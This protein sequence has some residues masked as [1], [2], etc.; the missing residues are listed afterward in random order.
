MGR[1][2]G[3]P[4]SHLKKDAV[5][6]T[7]L[8]PLFDGLA[9]C[10]LGCVLIGSAAAKDG[11]NDLVDQTKRQQEVAAQKAESDI[12]AS[13]VA[14]EKLASVDPAKAIDLLKNAQAKLEDTTELSE[15]RR[16]VLK[17]VFADRIRVAEAMIEQAKQDAKD[18]TQRADDADRKV[19]EEKIKRDLATI[20]VLRDSGKTDEA[21]RQA[22]ELARRFPNN[23]A[24]QASKRI[25]DTNE[26][27]AEARRLQ[28][29]KEARTDKVIGSDIT[30]SATPP[31]DDIEFPPPEQWARLT[32]A[33][34]KKQL[35]EKEQQILKTLDSPIKADFKDSRLEDVIDFLQTRTGLSII[36]D[37]AALDEANASYDTLVSANFKQ[38]VSVRTLLRVVLGKAGL[39]YIVKDEAITVMTPERAKATL[40][41]K[42]YYLGDLVGYTDVTL[43]PV[44]TQAK[45][46]AAGREIVEM[47]KGSVDPNSWRD[48]GGEGTIVFD[49]R[50]LSIIVKQTAEVHSILGSGYK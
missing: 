30:K 43:G 35:T 24:A 39:T 41:T 9:A 49:P 5:M 2:D 38:G 40:V 13:L 18:S 1:G 8:S 32:K 46:L 36:L 11:K 23:P 31:K 10:A 15:A 4:F 12:R 21:N 48:N 14:A 47:I 34:A 25:A 27:I 3:A 28:K 45:M 7:H 50:T 19:E 6:L 33:R 29:E 20:R 26:R 42:T 22:D 17:R 16:S 44:L 37:K